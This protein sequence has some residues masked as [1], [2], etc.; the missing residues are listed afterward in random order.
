M[1]TPINT[2]TQPLIPEDIPETHIIYR[3]VDITDRTPKIL[4]KKNIRTLFL[5]NATTTQQPLQPPKDP[6]WKLLTPE[7]YMVLCEYDN[8]YIG[9]TK[10]TLTTR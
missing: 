9:I 3:H 4:R 10:P 1:V 2:L 7:V 8:D 6:L 5:P